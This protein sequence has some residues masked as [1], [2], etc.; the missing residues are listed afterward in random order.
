MALA[1]SLLKKSILTKLLSGKRIGKYLNEASSGICDHKIVPY[2]RIFPG[3][4]T[5][6]LYNTVK[7]EIRDSILYRLQK[8]LLLL[9][10]PPYSKST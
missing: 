1:F 8:Q 7:L 3:K 4:S 6:L 9:I 5:N 2:N 10:P